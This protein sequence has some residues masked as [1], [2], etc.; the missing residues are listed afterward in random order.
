MSSLDKPVKQRRHLIDPN[1]PQRP[2]DLAAERK[3]LGRVQRFVMS[4]LAVTTI[5]HLS[6]GLVLA[7]VLMGHPQPG[8]RVG[9]SVIAGA[10]GV[11]ALAVGR[12]IHRKPLL[13]P[14]LLLGLAPTA[15]GIWLTQR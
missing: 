10:F 11:I 13:S 4:V 2:R 6:A 1:A 5:L 3:S 15:V 14:W 9:L 7:A 12:A 8:A